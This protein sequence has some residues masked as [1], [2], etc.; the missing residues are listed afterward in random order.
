MQSGC[1]LPSIDQGTVW[2]G[3]S[4]VFK[5]AKLSLLQLNAHFLKK[6]RFHYFVISATQCHSGESNLFFK[7]LQIMTKLF[8]ITVLCSK[9]A[10]QH[11]LITSTI[12]DTKN[13][14]LI[15]EQTKTIN[16]LMNIMQKALSTK[17]GHLPTTSP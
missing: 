14:L 13:A 7:I 3:F 15:K 16:Q 11:V 17:S 6:S 12:K 9:T 1:Y 10:Q 5:F 4:Q 8:P 2:V